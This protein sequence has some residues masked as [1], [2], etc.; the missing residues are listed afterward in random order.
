MRTLLKASF[1]VSAGNQAIKN[2]ALPKVMKEMM[3]KL[4]PEASY[5]FPSNGK[6]SCIMIFDLKDP[7]EI[8]L[9]VEP[10]FIQ[11]NAEVELTPVMNAEDLQK[12][13]GIMTHNLEVA[14]AFN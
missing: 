13:L 6:R 2:G 8:P 12:G 10:L 3:E 14:G 9:V 7:S 4:K 11:M 5:F 1:D